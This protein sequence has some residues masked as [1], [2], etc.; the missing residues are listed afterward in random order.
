MIIEFDSKNIIEQKEMV[1]R[2]KI[3]DRNGNL[4][5][6]NITS[7]SLSARSAKIKNKF[8]LAKKL[9][10]IIDIDVDE[11]YNNLK[12]KKNI[13]LKKNISPKENQRIIGLGEINL[14]TPIGNKRIYPYQ[15]VGSHI[16]GYVD[17]DS[18]GLAGAERGFEDHLIAGK[19]VFLTIDINLQNAVRNEL[20]NT[21]NKFS[22]DSGLVIIMDV[23]TGEI[24][25]SSSYPDF[26]P[27]NRK[28]FNEDSLFNRSIQANYE[29][30]STFKPLTVAMGF[31]KNLIKPGMYFDVSKPIK[32][33]IHDYHP[34]KGTY[35]IKEIIVNSSNI[36]SAKMAEVIGK[37]NQK[38]FFK[39]IGFTEKID[40]QLLEV[41]KPMG[42]MHN[43]GPIETMTIGYGHGYAVTPL[44]LIAAYS[45][46]ANKGKKIKP[47][48]FLDEE[49]LI[50]NEQI[51]R[52]ETSSYIL[53]LLRAVVTETKFTGSQ[54]KIDGYE[55]GG[56]TGTADLVKDGNYQKHENL[57]SFLGI[58]PISNPKYAVLAIIENP[59]KTKKIKQVTGATVSTPLVKKIILRMIE[60]LNMPR[61]IND[62]IL[63]AATTI[64]NNKKNVIN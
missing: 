59:K 52:E 3:Y 19:D 42:N 37:E 36:G 61:I 60:I 21:I 15:N 22:A 43:W 16:V 2:G 11:I 8:E 39:K 40:I 45:M 62:E 7:Y 9:S 6:S 41:A 47:K 26:D 58:F 27:N 29:M 20:L 13:L 46:I 57:T 51:I 56:K 64:N 12:L 38:D 32:N 48:I 14:T 44:H 23:K 28:T 55:I 25:S 10:L 50:Y 30:G 63:N 53:S 4:L 49:N 33:T 34:Y 54:I 18:R 31:E 24:L 17:T 1:E 35:S 5:A